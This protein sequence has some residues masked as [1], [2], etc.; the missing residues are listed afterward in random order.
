LVEGVFCAAGRPTPVVPAKEQP[1]GTKVADRAFKQLGRRPLKLV[2]HSGERANSV[3]GCGPARLTV[4][5][6]SSLY[7]AVHFR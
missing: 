1:A 7:A 2:R 6:K 5:P 3:S 4:G